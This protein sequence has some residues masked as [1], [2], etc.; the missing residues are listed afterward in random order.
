[1]YN[2]KLKGTPR[3]ISKGEFHSGGSVGAAQDSAFLREFEPCLIVLSR[4]TFVSVLRGTMC[5][6]QDPTRVDCKHGEQAL[7]FLN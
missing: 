4:E 3:V 5:D 6:V 2:P 1:M 7:Y